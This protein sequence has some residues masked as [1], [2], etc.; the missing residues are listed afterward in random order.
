MAGYAANIGNFLIILLILSNMKKIISTALILSSALVAAC[1]KKVEEVAPA[2]EPVAAAAPAIA[3]ASASTPA[4]APDMSDEQKERAQKQILLDY[5]VMEDQY[6]NDPRAQWATSAKASSTFGDEDG[7]TPSPSNSAA[8]TTGAAD[9]KEW[10]NNKQ[11]IGF[12]WL[13]LTYDKPVAATEVRLVLSHGEGVEAL[14]KVEL[15]DTDGKWNTV[16]SGLSDVKADKRG[17]RTWFVRSFEKT[18]YKVKA[19]KFTIANNLE[20][21]YKTV[22]AAQLVGD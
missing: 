6:I 3:P 2:S 8:N 7:K 16:W 19:V 18:P 17:N 14:N 5:A 1:N 15:Q 4:P 13:E 11:D 10:T 21:G 9:G 22:D 20:R 12:D